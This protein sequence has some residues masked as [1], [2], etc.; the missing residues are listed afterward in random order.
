MDIRSFA[1]A[2]HLLCCGFYV[3][4]GVLTE[5]LQ[6]LEHHSQFLLSEHPNLKIEMG[7]PL[8][9]ARHAVLTDQHEDSQKHALRG[10]KKLQNAEGKG[11]ERFH[12]RNQVEIRDD[13]ARNQN[14]MRKKKFR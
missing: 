14:Y 10:N 4:P 6:H 5:L 7:A 1:E 3:H 11:I 13:P 9:L 8:G 2:L 12:A